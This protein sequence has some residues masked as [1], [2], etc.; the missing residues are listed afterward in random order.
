[1][2]RSFHSAES[3]IRGLRKSTS[4]TAASAERS[5]ATRPVQGVA[6]FI[7]QLRTVHHC[8]QVPWRAKSWEREL[9]ACVSDSVQK[10]DTR[11]EGATQG[12]VEPV[13][14][15]RFLEATGRRYVWYFSSLTWNVCRYLVPNLCSTFGPGYVSRRG[16]FSPRN[17]AR[18]VK[19]EH[20]T[21]RTIYAHFSRA[22]HFINAHALA[23]DEL[24]IRVCIFSNVV[25]CLIAICSVSLIL[26]LS[27]LPRWLRN[28]AQPAPIH[29]AVHGLAEWL[30]RA[31]SQLV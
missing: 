25:T 29:G 14:G 18:N 15:D 1:M 20:F 16:R 6:R 13:R 31:S 30:N 12:F 3:Y 5:S 2:H 9:A 19:T 8:R 7:G 24:S 4:T 11:T 21:V 10:Y 23:Q 26:L 17:V 28:Q 22:R 27:F